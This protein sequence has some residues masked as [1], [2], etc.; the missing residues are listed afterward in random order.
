MNRFDPRKWLNIEKETKP[1]APKTVSVTT[2]SSTLDDI[3]TITQRIEASQLDIT[4]GYAAWRDLGFALA[5]ELGE[6]GR[7]YYQRLSRFNEEYSAKDTDDQYDKCLRAHGTGITIKTFFQ[8]AK[9]HGVNLST[10]VTREK[11]S[12][13]PISPDYPAE[14]IGETEEIEENSPTFSDQINKEDLPPFLS[15]ITDRA[16]STSDCDLLLLGSITA[17]SACFPFFRLPTISSTP[18]IFAALMVI[19]L[20]PASCGKPCFTASPAQIGRV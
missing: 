2:P 10:Q 3:E 17:I 4:S 13:S 15:K 6:A 8:M 1:T 18:Q 9:D 20:N 7:D 11:Y 12:K 5:E 14:N 19:A 16:L